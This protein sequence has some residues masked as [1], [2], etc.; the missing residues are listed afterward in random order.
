[1]VRLLAAQLVTQDSGGFV[2]QARRRIGQAA[3]IDDGAYAQPFGGLG[4]FLYPRRFLGEEGVG[5]QHTGAIAQPGEQLGQLVA[6]AIA[7]DQASGCAE[8]NQVFGS[9]GRS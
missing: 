4:V 9:H 1:M 5:D 7:D 6:R 3:G 8:M 2:A